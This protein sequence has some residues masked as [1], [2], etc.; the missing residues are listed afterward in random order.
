[1]SKGVSFLLLRLS[2]S[3]GGSL[4]GNLIPNQVK[5]EIGVTPKYGYSVLRFSMLSARSFF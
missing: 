3:W 4:G 5:A 1:M 2:L